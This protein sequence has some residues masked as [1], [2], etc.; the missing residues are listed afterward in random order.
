MSSEPLNI[1][2]NT[3]GFTTVRRTPECFICA[4]DPGP[5][6][7]VHHPD[8]ALIVSCDPPSANGLLKALAGRLV[9]WRK[10]VPLIG[11]R[12]VRVLVDGSRLA[13]K[14]HAGRAFELV[15]PATSIVLGDGITQ[16]SP[17]PPQEY[18]AR[19]RLL[20]WL[21]YDHGVET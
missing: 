3:C 19:Q 15:T 20:A 17:T 10:P 12:V 13:F 8:L 4:K 1:F 21:A 5:P 16:H 9:V 18:A 2:C 11:D 6:V 7:F 14:V